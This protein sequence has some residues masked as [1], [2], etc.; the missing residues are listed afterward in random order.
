M[1]YKV[2]IKKLGILMLPTFL[3]RP[4]VI[5]CIKVVVYPIEKIYDDWSRL[6]NEN[7]YTLQHTGQICYLRK[8][9]NDKLDPT[10]RRIYIGDGNKFRRQYIYTPVE[11]KPRYLGKII[12]HQSIDYADTGADF[13]VYAPKEITNNE[14]HQLR[15]LIELFKLGGKRYRIIAI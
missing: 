8:V 5:A 4:I 2:D 12:L 7:L 10:K 14:I 11:N 6:R 9:L 13:I 1:W 3:R 15:A